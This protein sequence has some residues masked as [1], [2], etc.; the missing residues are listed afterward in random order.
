[1]DN[2][3]NKHSLRHFLRLQKMNIDSEVQLV[4]AFENIKL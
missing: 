2:E 3:L 4:R 1:M